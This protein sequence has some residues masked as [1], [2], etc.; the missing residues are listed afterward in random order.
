MIEEVLDGSKIALV[1]VI[2]SSVG[3]IGGILSR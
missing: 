1:D 2:N 3:G